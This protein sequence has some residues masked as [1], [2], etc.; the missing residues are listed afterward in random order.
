MNFERY[1]DKLCNFFSAPRVKK[2]MSFLVPKYV[3][4]TLYLFSSTLFFFHIVHICVSSTSLVG[5]VYR[6]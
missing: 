1:V 3:V 6:L 5:D 4:K 2:I